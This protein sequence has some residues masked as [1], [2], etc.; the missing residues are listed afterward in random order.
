MSRYL[1]YEVNPGEGFNLRRDVYMRIANLV[2]FLSEEKDEGPW[3]IVLPPWGPL[4]HW[5]NNK[6]EQRALP[7]GLFF[8]LE[9]LRK[10]VPVIEFTD[11]LKCKYMCT[12]E[13]F[14]VI[15]SNFISYAVVNESQN[16][17]RKSDQWTWLSYI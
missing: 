7:W 10:Y 16:I 17:R 8:D 3:V 9:S 5:K 15:F 6:E 4:Y 13:F 2:K 1:L 12:I 14:H 11:F